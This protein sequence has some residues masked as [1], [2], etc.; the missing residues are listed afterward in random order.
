MKD[1]IKR[2][3]WIV[4]LIAI[5]VVIIVC[6]QEKKEKEQQRYEIEQLCRHTIHTALEDMK[7]YAETGEESRYYSGVAEFR[8]FMQIYY[9]LNGETIP[10]YLYCNEVYGLMLNQPEKVQENVHKLIPALEALANDYTDLNGYME[11]RVFYNAVT[12]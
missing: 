11:L 4:G 9:G 8:A 12:I 10:E 5:A 2:Y 1:W 6:F 3:S 7:G